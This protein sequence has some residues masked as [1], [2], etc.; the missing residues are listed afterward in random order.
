MAIMIVF[1]ARM[2]IT[3]L[4]NVKILSFVMAPAFPQNPTAMVSKTVPM[5]KMNETV[6]SSLKVYYRILTVKLK[7]PGKSMGKAGYRHSVG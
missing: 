4:I 6:L 1:L 2:N 3:V 7:I 5:V